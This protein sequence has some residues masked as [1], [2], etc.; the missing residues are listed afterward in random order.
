MSITLW[1]TPIGKIILA[2]PVPENVTDQQMMW[3]FISKKICQTD[4][5]DK[6]ITLNTPFLQNLKPQHAFFYLKDKVYH[7]KSA[8]IN[9][10]KATIKGE[11][12][13]KYQIKSFAIY[14]KSILSSVSAVEQ[15]LEYL[16]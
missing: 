3:G 5:Q 15:Q 7:I 10:L 12:T 2:H 11:K 16:Q 6:E 1:S 9:E 13:S 14:S 8:M 4:G